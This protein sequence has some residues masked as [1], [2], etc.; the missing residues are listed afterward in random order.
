MKGIENSAP[1]TK[2]SRSRSAFA[3]PVPRMMKTTRFLYALSLN[4]P[5]NW[6][7]TSDQNPRCHDA[8]TTGF[9]GRSEEEVRCSNTATAVS[10]LIRISPAGLLYLWHNPA[11]SPARAAY[12]S[13]CSAG[14]QL[15]RGAVAGLCWFAPTAN[16]AR[17]S[18]DS[19]T[20]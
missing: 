6:V 15:D 9:S 19:G 7:T 5:W 11:A 8:E 20:G 13:Y 12:R 10:S 16:P 14:E 1:P 4:A 17:V 3:S 18:P 2:T